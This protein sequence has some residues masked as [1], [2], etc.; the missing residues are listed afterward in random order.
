MKRTKPQQHQPCRLI[1]AVENTSAYAPAYLSLE[2]TPRLI[3]KLEAAKNFIASQPGIERVSISALGEWN[4]LG[5]GGGSVT[6]IDTDGQSLAIHGTETFRNT[7][8][9]TE[10]VDIE[11]L[12]EAARRNEDLVTPGASGYAL[13]AEEE[14]SF[15]TP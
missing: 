10:S 9:C 14:N 4:G 1:A 6:R 3:E 8:F 11:S 7:R 13:Y 2:I 12:L 5:T 15:A